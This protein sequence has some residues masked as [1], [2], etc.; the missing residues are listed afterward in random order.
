M[1]DSGDSR[2]RASAPGSGEDFGED[3]VD[4]LGSKHF[5]RGGLFTFSGAA[6]SVGGEA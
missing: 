2:P 4:H 3:P 6:D 1:R 5:M